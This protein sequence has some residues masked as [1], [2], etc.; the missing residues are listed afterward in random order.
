AED[1][2]QE[3]F[4]RIYQAASRFQARGRVRTWVFTIA[5]NLAMN[6]LKRRRRRRVFGFLVAGGRDSVAVN[7]LDLSERLEL[8]ETL[9]KA[10]AQLPDNQRAA[11]LLRVRDEL[12]Y[13]EIGEILGVSRASVESLLFRARERLRRLLRKEAAR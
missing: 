2:T 1:V 3:V 6:E 7:P 8:E 10:L 4:L 13:Q 12:S 5:Y 11:L 9:T